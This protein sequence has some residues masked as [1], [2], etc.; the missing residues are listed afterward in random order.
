VGNN[1][2]DSEWAY[3]DMKYVA[4]SQNMTYG[5]DVREL[6]A[7]TYEQYINYFNTNPNKTYLSVMFCIDTLTVSGVD[8]PCKFAQQSDEL[9]IYSIAYNFTLAPNSFMLNPALAAYKYEDL[10]SLKVSLDNA[11]LSFKAMKSGMNPAP[12]M[13][14]TYS[15]YPMPEDRILKGFNMVSATG[16]FYF[17]FTPIITF[18]IILTE[19]VREKEYKLR[20]G[21]NMM[22]LNQGSFWMSWFITSAIFSAACSIMQ[23]VSGWCCRFDFFINTPF[24]ISFLVFFSFSITM[25]IFAFFV[26]TFVNNQRS[27]YTLSY[28][29]LIAGLALQAVF[30]RAELVYYLFYSDTI[31]TSGIILRTLFSLYPPFSFSKIFDDI[32]RIA[33]SHESDSTFQWIPGRRV[34]ASDLV[35]P[36]HGDFIL[37]GTY[38]AVSTMTTFGIM[39]LNFLLYMLL[40]WYLD[41]IIGENRGVSDTWLFFLKPSYWCP[42]RKKSRKTSLN[43]ETLVES[44]TTDSAAEEVEKVK[45]LESSGEDAKGIRVIGLSKVYRKYPLGIK[46]KKD[47]HALSQFYMDVK[48][49]EL[50]ALLGHNGAGKSTLISILTGLNEPSSGT[51]KICGLNI[52]DNINEIQRI[53]GLVPQFDILWD[54][55][56]AREH[57]TIYARLK[58]VKEELIPSVIEA[59][60]NEVKLLHVIDT[61]VRAYSGGMKRRLSVAVGGIGDPKI[62]IMDE[63]T[64]GMDPISRRQVWDLIQNMKKDKTFILTTHLMEEADILSDRIAIMAKGKLMCVQTPLYLKNHYGD[65]Y[66]VNITCNNGDMNEVSQLLKEILPNGKVLT[67]MGGSLVYSVPLTDFG[68]L[69]PIFKLITGSKLMENDKILSRLHVLIKDCGVSHT[70]IEEVFLKITSDAYEEDD[71]RGQ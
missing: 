20:L 13:D 33:S 17:Y 51:A 37:R 4:S 32:T 38:T 36:I 26:S 12:K 10:F 69:S 60:L 52:K 45:L 71:K 29:F 27:A 42:A 56:T 8:I 2:T 15:D 53:T 67:M 19:L 34:V 63:P 62:I 7:G 23:I 46:S 28:A 66:K 44:K 55:L 70:S 59:K 35:N 14:V 5:T 21:L 24:W 11:M 1:L 43:R 25:V 68:K 54:E 49:G 64:T 48:E 61:P 6:T 22:G 3:Y 31:E 47:L 9:Y 39:G 18:I 40:A 41:H 16:T 57:L 30:S 65:G 58:G 50:L